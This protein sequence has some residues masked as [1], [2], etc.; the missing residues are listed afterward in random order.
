MSVTGYKLDKA[1]RVINFMTTTS[2]RGIADFIDSDA[3]Q[4]QRENAK[5]LVACD[6]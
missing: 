5:A 4:R 2:R 3:N 1:T 6:V